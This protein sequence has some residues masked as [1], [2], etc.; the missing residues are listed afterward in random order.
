MID[1]VSRSRN[2][3]YNNNILLLHSLSLTKVPI[4]A[5]VHP[6]STRTEKDAYMVSRDALRKCQGVQTFCSQLTEDGVM[7]A[8]PATS[9][10]KPTATLRC[11]CY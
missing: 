10:S 1:V 4:N 7:S 8:I 5:N 11:L 2:V 9:V 3:P 6:L